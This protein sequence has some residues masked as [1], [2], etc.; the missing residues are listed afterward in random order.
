MFP[1]TSKNLKNMY[2]LF[3]FYISFLEIPN[4]KKNMKK[5]EI[6][7]KDLMGKIYRNIYC[8]KH[9]VFEKIIRLIKVTE[10]CLGY[11]CIALL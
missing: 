2:Y 4:E 10:M 8:R 11:R 3:L 6:K 7:K 9:Y 1:L 5:K